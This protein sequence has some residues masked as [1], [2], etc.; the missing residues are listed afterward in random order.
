MYGNLINTVEKD[1]KDR[2][3]ICDCF[4][5]LIKEYMNKQIYSG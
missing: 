3:T 2:K 4:S 1:K 5:K